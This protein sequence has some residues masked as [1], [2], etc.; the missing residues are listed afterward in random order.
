MSSFVLDFQVEGLPQ[1]GF[2]G[3]STS[4]EMKDYLESQIATMSYH[5]ESLDP[6]TPEHQAFEAKLGEAVNMTKN[7]KAASKAKKQ[8]VRVQT[9]HH[10]IRCLKRTQSY[11]GL[12]AAYNEGKKQHDDSTEVEPGT[13]GMEPALNIHEPA[14]YP[15][16]NEPVFIS[17]DVE[18]NERCHF[19]VTEIGISVLDTRDLVN[20]PPGE[21]ATNWTTKIRSRHL[22]VKEYSHVVNHDFVTGCP[23]RFDF[24]DS[25]WASL[26]ELPIVIETC[27]QHFLSQ[28]RNLVLVGH[29]PSA[30]V[31]YLH[32]LGVPLFQD[33]QHSLSVFLETVDT[34]EM[35]R[36]SRHEMT[37]RS[38]GHIL[39][40]F[41]VTGWYLH[42]AGN[43]ARY[44][45]EAMVLCLL[46]S[47][48][49]SPVPVSS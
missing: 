35:F 48:F 11:F 28:Q 19:Q 34:A 7:K 8:Q 33:L 24:G 31:R 23:D 6:A 17:V 4:R 12:R 37:V 42:N 47:P 1:P 44:T 36:V 18:S 32:E 21:T 45:M 5:G 10:W 43:D 38:L 39:A 15:Y 49:G 40:A 3:Q 29:N 27:F 16:V 30:D 46:H 13:N 14:P 26:S 22:R 25:E 2:L 20:T 41:G 9:E